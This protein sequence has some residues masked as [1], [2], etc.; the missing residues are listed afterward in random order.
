MPRARASHER[1][2]EDLA[3][4]LLLLAAIARAELHR[5]REERGAP[6]WSVLEHLDVPRRSRAARTVRTQLERLA[7]AGALRR[8]RVRGVDL[9]SLRPAGRRRLSEARHAGRLPELP[10]SPQH[11]RWREARAAAAEAIDGFRGRLQGR[12]ASAGRLLEGRPQASSDVWLELGEQLRRDCQ[13]LASAIHC[14]H[15]WPE[16][17]DADADLDERSEPSDGG[18]DAR[19]RARRRARRAG[20]RNVSLWGE[21]EPS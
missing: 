6:V 1:S 12:L 18:L 8:E 7:A 17:D 2:D 16:P 14:L 11:R 21:E 3:S 15:E 4:E 10:E 13:L 19:E 5:A 20:R 9:W